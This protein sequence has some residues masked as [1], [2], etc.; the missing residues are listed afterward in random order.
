MRS[1]KEAT[2]KEIEA[3]GPPPLPPP[4]AVAACGAP[5]EPRDARLARS[6]TRATW[7]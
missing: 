4:P 2:S 1:S 6:A 5:V 7:K 3:R